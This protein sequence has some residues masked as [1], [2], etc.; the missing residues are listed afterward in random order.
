MSPAAR[1]KHAR[2]ALAGML[3]PATW[4]AMSGAARAQEAP[5]APEATTTTAAAPTTT[6]PPST[7]TTLPL[8][9]KAQK[10]IQESSEAQAYMASR[11]AD[12]GAEAPPVAEP[13]T[14]G[15][16]PSTISVTPTPHSIPAPA[17]IQIGDWSSPSFDPPAR[18]SRPAA[19]GTAPAGPAATGGTGGT[20]ESPFAGL[21]TGDDPTSGFP[22]PGTGATFDLGSVPSPATGGA[23]LALGPPAAALDAAIDPANGQAPN[24]SQTFDAGATGQGENPER[25]P[26]AAAIT[27]GNADATGNRTVTTIDQT[28]MIAV[29]KKGTVSLTTAENRDTGAGWMSATLPSGL[30]GGHAAQISAAGFGT[31]NVSGTGTA[32][33]TTG[34]AIAVGNWSDTT[35]N[36]TTLVAVT[37]NGQTLVVDQPAS[38]FNVGNAAANTGGNTA[39]GTTNGGGGSAVITTGNATAYGNRSTTVI[40]QSALVAVTGSNSHVWITQSATVDNIGTATATTGDNTATGTTGEGD[41]NA[42]I[43]TGNAKA[44]GNESSTTINQS[45]I[46][47]VTGNGS[48]ADIDQ[49]ANVNNVG[50]ANA[51]TGGN[52]AVATS[53][54]SYGSVLITTGDADATGNKAQTTVTQR[55]ISVAT[56]RFAGVSITQGA[57]VLN[58]G[59]ALA[60][61]GINTAVGA[62]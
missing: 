30:L 21:P 38:V 42:A 9:K 16:A 17:S 37:A 28:T 51:S 4:L 14:S 5:P 50:T 23:D 18:P 8:P 35:I 34:D 12:E 13:I 3:V 40:N 57:G 33:I 29:T 15:I 25:G 1:L 10:R 45:G 26:P 44:I 32:T 31:G 24:A 36:Q 49:Q 61:S 7:T 60:S 47:A 59:T 20:G 39:T 55:G 27:T 62:G 22:I 46:V 54:G 58:D 53:G 56:G 19:Q 43:H 41:G 48:T 2:H 11:G 6:T 52:A